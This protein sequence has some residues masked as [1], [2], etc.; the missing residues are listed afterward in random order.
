MPRP[1]KPADKR[2]KP[3]YITA[4]DFIRLSQ[5]AEN[6]L[7]ER[8][9]RERNEQLVRSHKSKVCWACIALLALTSL[10]QGSPNLG[11]HLEETSFRCL[12]ATLILPISLSLADNL[13]VALKHRLPGT[14]LS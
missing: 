4:D 7:H 13:V 14:Q 6:A 1:K 3:E 12:I 9:R 8:Q 10:A 5:E 11:F 2:P